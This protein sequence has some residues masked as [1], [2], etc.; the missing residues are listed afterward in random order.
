M[1]KKIVTW[2]EQ[3]AEHKKSQVIL[4]IVAFTESSFF[5]VPPDVLIIAILSHHIKRSW[6]R[7]ASIATVGSVLGGLFGYA[8]GYYFYQYIGLPIVHFYHL[9][10]QVVHVG[11]L[12]NDNAFLAILIATFTPIPY[13]VF[14]IAG[15]L[16][17]INIVTFV[18]A[19]IIGRGARF[20]LVAYMSH[21]FGER[22][23]QMILN[24]GDKILW[25]VG[26]VAFVVI[27]LL[28]K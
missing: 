11:Q 25:V 23:K 1:V 17:S 7:I 22:A 3:F 13:K 6:V 26:I 16:F 24:K 12:F 2:V 8:I 18:V 15:G 4:F 14:T 27:Y 19:S 10:E 9:E 28:S 20:F 21:R 5:L